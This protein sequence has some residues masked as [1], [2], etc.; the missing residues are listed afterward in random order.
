MND[1]II[2]THGVYKTAHLGFYRK[3]CRSRIK[4]AVDGGLRF[5][6]KSN[7]TPH[8][9]IGDLDSLKKMPKDLSRLTK[10]M[11]FPAKKDKTDLHLAFEYCLSKHAESIDV[12][13]PSFGQPD[14]FLGNVMLVNLVDKREH[15]AS[16]TMIRFVN[17][18]Y[19]IIFVSDRTETF[20]NCPGHLV[21]VIPFS[22]SIVLT[23]S[24]SEYDVRNLRIRCGDSRGTRN[25]IVSRQATFDIKGRA[26]V[27]HYFSR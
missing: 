21:S 8:L 26:F 23:C 20:V 15:T 2:F 7:I 11:T 14:H 9:L 6:L 19:E 17:V 24:G 25:R 22:N 5:F 1:Y 13:L 4:V 16:T 18:R 27:I 10:V 3:R 12:V